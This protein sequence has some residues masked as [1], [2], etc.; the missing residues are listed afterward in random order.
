MHARVVAR[1]SLAAVLRSVRCSRGARPYALL[2]A[3]V[4]ARRS[5]LS[6]CLSDARVA[7]YVEP[8]AVLLAGHS[9]GGKL[10]TLLASTDPRVKGLALIDPVDV[11]Q[12]TPKGGSRCAVEPQH[13]L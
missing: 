7:P 1:P 13:S 4:R 6:L 10:S 11:T 12:M 8:G 2:H 3:C 5:I 9:R